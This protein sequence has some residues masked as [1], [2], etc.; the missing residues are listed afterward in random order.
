MTDPFIRSLLQDFQK[1]AKLTRVSIAQ[2]DLTVE[3]LR[4]PH[5]PPARLP[6]GQ[7][8]VYIFTLNDECLKVGKVGPKSNARYVSQ[9]YNPK[10]SR[11]NLAK[12]VLKAKKSL[13]CKDI[14]EVSVGK[15]IKGNTDRLNILLPAPL[16]VTVL[17]LLESFLQCRLK[18]RFEGFENQR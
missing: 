14:D 18:P 11:S 8:A 13:G 12:S 7:M 4:A 16:G 1:V 2:S 17:S 15:W 9:H 10:S 3:M 6:S 5:I